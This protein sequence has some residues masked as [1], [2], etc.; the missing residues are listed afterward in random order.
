MENP[1]TTSK[2]SIQSNYVGKWTNTWKNTNEIKSFEIHE[3]NNI[4]WMSFTDHFNHPS[5]LQKVQIDTYTSGP[6]SDKVIAFGTIVELENM[7]CDMSINYN[8]GILIIACFHKFKEGQN[9]KNYFTRQFYSRV[10]GQS[11][12]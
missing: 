10:G 8:K 9:K 11:S 7:T 2:P 6:D 5:T 12:N 1:Q 4:L 3:V